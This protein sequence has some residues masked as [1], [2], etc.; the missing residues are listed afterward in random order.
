MLKAPS[1][2]VFDSGAGGL[3]IA[4]EIVALFPAIDI[5]YVA[6]NAAFPYGS[7]SDQ[8]LIDRVLK[9][10]GVLIRQLSPSIVVIACNTASTLALSHLR[11]CFS[12]PFVGVVPAIKPAAALTKSGVI[13][14]LATPATIEREYTDQ[15]IRDYA[16]HCSVHKVGSTRLVH[17]AEDQLRGISISMCALNDEIQQLIELDRTGRMDTIVLGCTHYPLLKQLLT[18]EPRYAPI[19]WVDSGEAIA[20]RV[21]YHLDNLSVDCD[22][23]RAG[24]IRYVF[25]TRS[26]EDE[27]YPHYAKYLGATGRSQ[28]MVVTLNELIEH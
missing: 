25:T 16:R 24:S 5:T 20:R 7:M 13:G 19:R 14:I 15:L 3:T 28:Q 4:R 18:S 10:M 17:L 11:E 23:G 2:L 12:T 8:A 6:D 21:A 9:I 27:V 1:I 22:T 26:G